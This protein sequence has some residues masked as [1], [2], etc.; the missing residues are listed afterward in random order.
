MHIQLVRHAT[1][2]L[3]MNGFNIAVDPLLSPAGALDPTVPAENDLR[4]PLVELPPRFSGFGDL[5]AVIVTHAHRDHLDDA[6]V[7]MLPKELPLFCQPEDEAKLSERGFR[8]VHAVKESESWNGIRLTRTGGRHGTGETARKMGPVSGFVLQS[9]GEPVLYIVGDSVWCPEVGETLSRH[10]PDV[11]IV[12]AGAARFLTGG[13]IT[14]TRADIERV[15]LKLPETR[16][17]T[18]HMEAWNHCMLSRGELRRYLEE[19]GLSQRV[20]IPDDGE[21][22]EFPMPARN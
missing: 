2:F 15:C 13:P 12:N 19:R 4:N 22:M 20:H 1:L 10:K 8:N 17:I 6:A 7:G 9:E 5:D 21:W 18:V 3:R 16:V 14:M 11:T